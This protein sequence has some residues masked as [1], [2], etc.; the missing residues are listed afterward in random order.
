MNTPANIRRLQEIVPDSP[1]QDIDAVLSTSTNLEE[2]IEVLVSRSA[3]VGDA[4][5]GPF[6]TT[7]NVVKRYQEE[8][9][10]VDDGRAVIHITRENLWRDALTFYKC[11]MGDKQKLLRKLSVSFNGEDGIDAGALMV[12]FFT[13]LFNCAKENLFEPIEGKSWLLVPKRSGGNLQIFKIVG[14]FIAHSILQGGPFFNFLAPWVVDVLVNNNG[15]SGDIPLEH[16]PINSATGGMIN[17]I[18]SLRS[19]ENDEAIDELFAS[20]DGPAFEQIISTSDWEPNQSIIVKNKNILIDMLLYEETIVRSGR[21]ISAIR[22]GLHFLGFDKHLNHDV[23]KS[24]F[25]GSRR[26][27]QN[28]E[29]LRL[30]E[31][32]GCDEEPDKVQCVD[33]FKEFIEQASQETL[34]SLL[35]FSTGFEDAASFGDKP[36]FVEFLTNEK[37]PKAS[38]CATTLRL[39]MA[40]GNKEEFFFMINK[41]LEFE[42]VGFGDF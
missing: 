38:A 8:S 23:T 14:V 13:L 10:K 22:E 36:I 40:I 27:I 17:F 18:K 20:A 25:L 16:I 26:L 2:A 1:V 19:C 4:N 32:D 33:W 5:V 41:A 31:F 37:L 42:S 11:N 7:A 9:F 34:V 15:I 30:F 12:E 24:M 3:D 29:F 21:K 35:R 6:E 39:P 28:D